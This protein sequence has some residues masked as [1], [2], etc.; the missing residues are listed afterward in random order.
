MDSENSHKHVE[1]VYATTVKVVEKQYG[2][3]WVEKCLQW[4]FRRPVWVPF[5]YELIWV[6]YVARLCGLKSWFFMCESI[7]NWA[8]H[9]RLVKYRNN[10]YAI[11]SYVSRTKRILQWKFDELST[12]T[13][14]LLM[15]EIPNNHLRC[16]KPTI[17]NG[18]SSFQLLTSSG[19]RCRIFWT[20]NQG[21]RSHVLQ[22]LALQGC[23]HATRDASGKKRL[24]WCHRDLGK[25]VSSMT[26]TLQIYKSLRT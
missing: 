3:P 1:S 6:N 11:C 24:D 13:S 14:I 18:I 19:G 5:L 22:G 7:P 8:N 10:C 20:I 17:N 12:V 23:K 21:Y 25:V 16:I 4:F 2:E 15:E 26:V 9:F